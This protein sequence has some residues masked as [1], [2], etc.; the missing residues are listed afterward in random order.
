MTE[1]D[2]NN[3]TGSSYSIV[4]GATDKLMKM[5]KNVLN[6]RIRMPI[7][8]SDCPRNFITKITSYKKICSIENS[9]TCLESLMDIIIHMI[10]HN[11]TGTYNMV[12]E[13]SISHNDILILYKK[14]VN[15]AFTWENFTIDEQDKVLLSKRS[16][17]ILS[18]EK[19]KN[20]MIKNN[21]NKNINIK[22]NI[23]EGLKHYIS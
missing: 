18:T 20:Y 5:Y 4:K 13:N 19:L 6:L 10:I 17:V 21:I 3:F 14:Y 11:E 7:V 2:E 23:E 8:F 16:N 15:N 22:Y 12:N 1:E 9:M